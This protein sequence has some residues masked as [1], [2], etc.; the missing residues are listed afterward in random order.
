Y[1]QAFDE[2]ISALFVRARGNYQG[3]GRGGYEQR[4]AGPRGNP[5]TLVSDTL[6]NSRLMKAGAAPDVT[7][8]EAVIILSLVNHPELAQA[9][10]ETLA[11]LEFQSLPARQVLAAFL[12]LAT[13]HPDLGVNGVHEALIAR[14]HG[15]VLERMR[16]LLARQ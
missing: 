10:I 1:S 14:G 8:R 3:R 13:V 11:E 9:R 2:K 6:R 12:D 16:M 7:P 15:P 5:R 4:K